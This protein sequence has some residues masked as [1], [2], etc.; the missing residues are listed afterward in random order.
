[1]ADDNLAVQQE[2]EDMLE[3]VE[4]SGPEGDG[5]E[6]VSAEGAEEPLEGTEVLE[7]GTEPDGLQEPGLE[8]ALP[9]EERLERA[10]AA[11]SQAGEEEAEADDLDLPVPDEAI[12]PTTPGLTLGYVNFDGGSADNTTLEAVISAD[13]RNHFRR[14]MYVGIQD[15]QQDIEFLGRIVQGPFHIPAGPEPETP[16]YDTYGH[17]EILGQLLQG[18]RV[19]PSP[20]RPRPRSEIFIFPPDRLRRLLSIDGNMLI[21]SLSGYDEQKVEVRADTE[22]KNFLPLNVGIFG[23]VGSGKSNTVQVLVEEA[24][25]ANWACVVID[26]EGEYVGMSEPG[27]RPEMN[28][29]LRETYSIEPQGVEDFRVYVPSSG[30]SEAQASIR[31]KVPVSELDISIISDI[32]DFSEPEFRMYEKA[33]EATQRTH[34]QH[35]STRAGA[36][37]S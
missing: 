13:Q 34:L 31:F 33:V 16:S 9:Q 37:V 26:V 4:V 10:E 28:R 11:K 5:P 8:E 21:G 12:Q 6:P 32:L 1:M 35:P 24:S 14:E 19:A 25:R 7:G 29:I 15:T 23:T 30:A 18:E 36:A 2:E 27:Q 17:I 22:N 20:T 3:Q